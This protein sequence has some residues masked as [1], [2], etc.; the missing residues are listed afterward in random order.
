[1]VCLFLLLIINQALH[2]QD[3]KFDE[4][5]KPAYEAALDLNITQVHSLIPEPKTVQDHYV[6]SL[7]EA[8]ELLITEDAE[9]FKEY[10]NNFQSR[11]SKKIKSSTQE[12]QFLQAEMHLQWAFIYLKFGHELDAA[13]SLREA[14]LITE[15]CKKKSPEYLPIKKTSG[16]LEVIMGSV[17][18]K[19]NWILGLLGM[20]GSIQ[21]GL[22]D[23]ESIRTSDS[24]LAFEANLIYALIHGFVLQHPDLA[25]AE[26]KQLVAEKP[27][28]KLTLFLAGSL[29]IKN[30]QS[31]EA[32]L[33][34]NKLSSLPQDAPLYYTDYQKGEIYLHKA[35]YLNSISSYRSFINHY[36][37]QNYI[38]DA[39]YKIGLCY[40]LNGNIN[41]AYASFKEAKTK[42]IEATEADK[43]AARSLSE[44]ELPHIELSKVRYYTDGGFY[45]EAQKILETLTIKELPTQRDQV[46]FYYRKA[47]L[48]HK[49][50]Q[51]TAAKTF[52]NQT[53]DMAGDEPWYFAPNA[54]LQLAYMAR[55]THDEATAKK[56]F[57]RAL[58]Y[59]KHEYKN[60]IDSKAKSGLAQI[61]RK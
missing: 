51:L 8:L 26:I 22:E 34:L 41:D 4:R 29:L 57:E 45:L 46:E 17:P 31:E 38:K 59:K 16:M 56:Y 9:K 30:S 39:Y 21:S 36:N 55:D 7:A 52:Y 54:C 40:W 6:I 49:V 47:R 50:N 43:S 53:I 19:Y 60:S 5:T 15:A 42:G 32:L 23:L 48:A 3:L 11:Q 35:D 28:S 24:A 18:E 58:S 12:Y 61:K 2:A 14:Y 37:G 33:M 20:K 1:M 44:K 25:T 27:E 10:E 13:V